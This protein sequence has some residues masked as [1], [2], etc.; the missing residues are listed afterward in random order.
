MGGRQQRLMLCLC[1]TLSLSAYALIPRAGPGR[2][3]QGH[4]SGQ[5]LVNG[6]P[7]SLRNYTLLAGLVPQDDVMHRWLTVEENL[8]TYARLRQRQGQRDRDVQAKVDRVLRVLGIDHIRHHLIGD[9]LD[10][11][12][13][14]GQRK[15]RL[16][17]LRSIHSAS[18]S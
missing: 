7:D 5:V 4:V 3:A 18:V 17:L 13:S 2:E 8:T 16:C 1:L 6:R 15:V 12:I 10:R 11:G 9:A 14:G